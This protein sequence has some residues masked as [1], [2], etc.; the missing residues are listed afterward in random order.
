M[1]DPKAKKKVQ[2]KVN[3]GDPVPEEPAE[4]GGNK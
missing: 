3:I 1:E 2:I 4:K